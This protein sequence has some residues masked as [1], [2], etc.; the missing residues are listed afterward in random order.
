MSI[1]RPGICSCCDQTVIWFKSGKRIVVTEYYAE[2]QLVLSDGSI[3]THSICTMCKA[4]LTPGD[5]ARVFGRIR[6]TWNGEM[7]GWAKQKDFDTVKDLTVAAHAYTH[8]DA[9]RKLEEYREQKKREKLAI[10]E[11]VSDKQEGGIH[12]T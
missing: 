6:D 3:A 7:A 12:G 4:K 1:I 5:V 8:S 9:V 10:Q 11:K 2:F